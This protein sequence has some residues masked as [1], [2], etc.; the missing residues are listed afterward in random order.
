MRTKLYMVNIMF[1]DI[2]RHSVF[3]QNRIQSPKRCGLKYKQDGVLNKN[4]TMDN[5]K[6]YNICTNVPLSQT[7]RFYSVW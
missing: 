5:A 4:R 3:I 7:F 1:L 6:K 2:I